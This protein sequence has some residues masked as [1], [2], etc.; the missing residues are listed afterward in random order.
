MPNMAQLRPRLS[1]GYFESFAV[2]FL[3]NESCRFTWKYNQTKLIQRQSLC[4]FEICYICFLNERTCWRQGCCYWVELHLQNWVYFEDGFKKEPCLKS[5]YEPR[6]ICMI[7]Q[8]WIVIHI[9][10]A[11]LI[12]VHPHLF[13]EFCFGDHS[14]TDSNRVVRYV[15]WRA[16]M[17]KTA[18]LQ[19][20]PRT[21]KQE[22]RNWLHTRCPSYIM[23]TWPMN[24]ATTR[25]F[26]CNII[27]AVLQAFKP[28]R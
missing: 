22:Y 17:P 25:S 4:L 6:G 7:C 28:N 20:S 5:N 16:T 27:S 10:P 2:F 19:A 3:E 15:F 9:N 18:S 26:E 11:I 1:P 13:L 8:N 12:L 14:C 24:A 23:I 21:S